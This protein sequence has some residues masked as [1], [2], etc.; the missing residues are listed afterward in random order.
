MG[1]RR[2]ETTSA[3][4]QN[5]SRSA[6]GKIWHSETNAQQRGGRILRSTTAEAYRRQNLQQPVS[7]LTLARL[8]YRVMEGP[9]RDSAASTVSVQCFFEGTRN[10]NAYSGQR[11]RHGF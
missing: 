1:D 8:Q 10:N 5:N 2:P 6:Q 3:M 11:A 7:G 9:V 4:V